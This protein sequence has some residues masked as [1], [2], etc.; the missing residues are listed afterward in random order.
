MMDELDLNLQDSS[1][2]LVLERGA[3]S[4]PA[5]TLRMKVKF[6]T[7]DFKVFVLSAMFALRI[8]ELDPSGKSC[9]E[10][11]EYGDNVQA[12]LIKAKACLLCS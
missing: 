10:A 2:L 7:I 1:S 12:S 4:N 9:I 5:D 11:F 8:V 6:S 3:L